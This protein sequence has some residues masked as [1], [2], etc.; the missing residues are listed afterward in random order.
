[1]T[2]HFPILIVDDDPL[3]TEILSQSSK[4]GFPEASFL[5]VHSTDEAINYIKALDGYG[6]KLVLLDCYLQDT[7]NGL[8]FLAFLRSNS[9]TRYLPVVILTVSQTQADIDNA[10][11]LGASS[12]TVKPSCFDDWVT[13][14]KSLRHYWFKTVTIPR[15]RYQKMA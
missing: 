11:S 5:Q 9:Q 12:F 14:L 10:Y 8:D 15:I 4:L 7:S 2:S 6:P 1:M 13:Y 3:L